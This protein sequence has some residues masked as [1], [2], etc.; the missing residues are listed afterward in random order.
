MKKYDEN[1]VI[2]LEGYVNEEMYKIISGKA[3]VYLNYGEENEYLAGILSEQMC[4]GEYGPLFD[5]PSLYTV[6]SVTVLLV[7]PYAKKDMEFFI[8]NNHGEVFQIMHNIANISRIMK[9]NID[10]LTDELKHVTDNKST[11]GKKTGDDL[12]PDNAASEF[13]GLIIH[14][15]LSGNEDE[16]LS[17][18]FAK[19]AAAAED[20]GLSRRESMNL[21]LLAEEMI[22]MIRFITN[23][24]DAY[25]WIKEDD[26]YHKSFALHLVV[27][28]VMNA[29][30]KEK[31]M[32]ISS[33][34]DN[35]ASKGI[36]RKIRNIINSSLKRSGSVMKSGSS[37]Q[38]AEAYNT[39]PEKVFDSSTKIWSLNE[40]KEDVHKKQNEEDIGWA[41]LQQSIIANIADEIEVYIRNS[42]VGM[43]IYKS[44]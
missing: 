44:F 23:P 8:K 2:V 11:S 36:T 6:V 4:F 39:D 1:S 27:K 43:V 34:G 41:E 9:K 21:H 13:S 17:K 33:D 25:F 28:T 42:T 38:G 16:L 24:N 20:N 29:K 7:M 32:S 12:S 40:Y 31:L 3:A 19:I 30:K 10:M 35:T 18:A 22:G 26:K 15:S 5:T 14:T 37:R